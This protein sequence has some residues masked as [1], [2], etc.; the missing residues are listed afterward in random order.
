MN[1]LANLAEESTLIEC[2][3]RAVQRLAE[4]GGGM[5]NNWFCF[6]G[7]VFLALSAVGFLGTFLA[8]LGWGRMQNARTDLG[9]RMMMSGVGI[10]AGFLIVSRML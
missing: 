7:V 9:I 5:A 1:T 2:I 10:G 4:G 6:F 3:Q 8:T